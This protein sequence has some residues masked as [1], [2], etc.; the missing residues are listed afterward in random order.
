MADTAVV[1]L[2]RIV[3]LPPD[4][5][6]VKV[7]AAMTPAMSAWVALRRRVPLQAGQS[8]GPGSH[9]DTSHPAGNLREV[10]SS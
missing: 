9:Q 7:A 10:P 2:R 3:P 5:D 4:V 6:V 8:V 1:D